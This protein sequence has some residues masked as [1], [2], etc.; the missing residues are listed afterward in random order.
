MGFLWIQYRRK[1]YVSFWLVGGHHFK[2]HREDF[3]TIE[4]FIHYCWRDVLSNFT[5]FNKERLQVFLMYND[6]F[7][8]FQKFRETCFMVTIYYS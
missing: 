6:R 1:L 8:C 5:D 7:I 2:V 4:N 3:Q